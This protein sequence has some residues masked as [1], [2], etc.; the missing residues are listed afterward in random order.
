MPVMLKRLLATALVGIAPT[1][2]ANLDAAGLAVLRLAPEP[3]PDDVRIPAYY[4]AADTA[5]LDLADGRFRRVIWELDDTAPA[6]E[7]E[8]LLALGHHDVA[9]TLAD[10]ADD[11]LLA[12]RIELDRN[13]AADAADL[14]SAAIDRDPDAV[15]P[16]R[17]I[18]LAA[19]ALG[20]TE[21][22][23]NAYRWFQEQ[24]FTRRFAEDPDQAPFDDAADL[25]HIASALDRLATLT[26]AYR[27]EPDLHDEVLAMLVRA[28]DVVDRGHADAHTAAALFLFERSD[29]KAAQEE[30]VAALAARPTD[31]DA[32]ALLGRMH[33]DRFG[34]DEAQ[35]VVAALRQIDPASREADLI[36]GRSLLFQRQPDRAEPVIQRQ[37]DRDANDVRAL[38]LLAASRAMR[39]DEAGAY[40]LL[41]HADSVKP[42]DAVALFQVGEQLAITRQYDRA[43]ATLG[44]VVRRAPWWTAARNELAHVHVQAGNEAAAIMELRDARQLDPFNAE[45]ANYLQ[46]LEEMQAYAAQHTDHFIVRHDDS[47]SGNEGDGFVADLMA[48]WLD[49]M[50]DD[51]SGEYNWTPDR[52]TEIQLFPTH[53]RFSVRIAGDPYVGTVGACTGPVIALV[54]P[55][56][57]PDQLGTYDWARV[58]RHEYAHTITLGKTD[59]RVWHWLTEGL[60]V[61]SE[62]APIDQGQ[63]DLLSRATLTDTLFGIEDLTWG[64]VRPKKPTDRSQAY[65]QSWMVTEFW[66][67]KHGE[68]VVERILDACTRGLTER[69]A[70]AELFDTTPAAFDREFKAWMLAKVHSWGHDPETTKRYAAQIE[71]GEEAVRQRDWPTAIGAFEAA[72]ELRPHDDGPVKRLAGLYLMQDAPAVS[73]DKLMWLARRTT[74]DSR[75]AARAARL[76]LDLGQP[77]QALEAATF[78]LHGNSYDPDIRA[79]HA[80]IV[81]ANE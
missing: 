18:G 68:E 33:L 1:A 12:G 78:A 25:V 8:A 39:L 57:G 37:L 76:Y 10:A 14:F 30:I 61:R 59:N 29:L 70:L 5:R 64:F 47:K 45:S 55:L 27:T 13:R 21:T 67:D 19:E 54:A 15:A 69:Q 35:T 26:L 53:D 22:A 49:G 41:L 32:L 2:R 28:Y 42:G 17:Y 7:A 58:M 73:A 81:A 23:T 3:R 20:E 46:L 9:R 11:P 50:H 56:D 62:H 24:A 40:E 51:V 4:D 44:E 80:E 16:R 60:A 52:P 38:G 72:M 77:A 75:F 79:L 65:A 34:F 48:S 71:A 63:I 43:V 36:E 31:P 66:V 6:L 74:R